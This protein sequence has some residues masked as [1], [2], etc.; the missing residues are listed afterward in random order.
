VVHYSNHCLYRVSYY[1]FVCL[2]FTTFRGTAFHSSGDIFHFLVAFR[3]VRYHLS[4]GSWDRR[5]L[6]V[7]CGCAREVQNMTVGWR[8]LHDPEP[9]DLCVSRDNFR[10]IVS[11]TVE[12][13]AFVP[14]RNIEGM[15]IKL[16]T[17]NQKTMGWLFMGHSCKWKDKSKMQL[18][19][20][21]D[22]V[23]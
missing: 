16:Y 21:C 12:M 8:N 1:T 19:I 3:A 2:M 6:R 15:C 11:K 4:F 9:H 23:S 13:K 17:H 10:V 7:L 18:T 14:A 5:V 20:I 22:G